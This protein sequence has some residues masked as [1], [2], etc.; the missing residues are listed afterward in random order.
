MIFKMETV[1]TVVQTELWLNFSFGTDKCVALSK[2]LNF[3]KLALFTC[4]NNMGFQEFYEEQWV[5]IIVPCKE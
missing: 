3:S 5:D 2:F 4:K 1:Y